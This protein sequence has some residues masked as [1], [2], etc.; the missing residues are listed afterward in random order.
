MKTMETMKL[1]DLINKIANG[2]KIPKKILFND[3]VFDT[4]EFDRDFY[5]NICGYLSNKVSLNKKC[6]NK[7][8]IILEE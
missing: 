4:N 2:E 1:I 6:L 8:I 5:S 3:I 7:E